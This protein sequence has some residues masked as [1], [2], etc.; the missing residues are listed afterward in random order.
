MVWVF[1]F[2]WCCKRGSGVGVRDGG[3]LALGAANEAARACLCRCMQ[4]PTVAGVDVDSRAVSL[5]GLCSHRGSAALW[6][7]PA[8]REAS[9]AVCKTALVFV[10]ACC[11]FLRFRPSGVYLQVRE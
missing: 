11:L 8:V 9:Y 7:L 5:K 6:S 4:R 2:S 10:D 1:D 3:G